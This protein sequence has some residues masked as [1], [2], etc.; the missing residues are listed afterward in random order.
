[1]KQSLWIALFAFAL[2]A[3]GS[4][5]DESGTAA[6][7]VRPPNE[8]FVWADPGIASGNFDADYADCKA[9]VEK[10]PA[11]TPETPQLAVLAA[12]MKCMQPKGWKFVDPDA[13]AQP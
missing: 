2:A 4:S 12:Y 8:Y 6:K 13:P 5:N 7:P 3:C 1:M 9:Q 11:I 10:D